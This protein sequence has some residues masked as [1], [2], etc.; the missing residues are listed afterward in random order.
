[1]ESERLVESGVDITKWVINV[2]KTFDTAHTVFSTRLNGYPFSYSRD[3]TKESNDVYILNSTGR[4]FKELGI[5][6]NGPISI[7]TMD[8]PYSLTAQKVGFFSPDMVTKIYKHHVAGGYKID[9]EMASAVSG[10]TVLNAMNHCYYL[11][12]FFSLD[13][14]FEYYVDYLGSPDVGVCVMADTTATGIQYW[15]EV[16]KF[17]VDSHVSI[18]HGS[19]NLGE[20][21]NRTAFSVEN[22]QA[23]SYIIAMAMAKTMN[24]GDG[25]KAQV[26]LVGSRRVASL[27]QSLGSR[28]MTWTGVKQI[29]DPSKLK[30]LADDFV[31]FPILKQMIYKFL[32]FSDAP[33]Y[34]HVKMILK[35]TNML[36]FM[37]IHG[38]LFTDEPTMA[39]GDQRIFKEM[40][41]WIRNFTTIKKAFGENWPYYKI[42]NPVGDLTNHS[43]FKRL[44]LYAW[45]YTIKNATVSERRTMKNIK[46]LSKPPRIALQKVST[47]AVCGQSGQQKMD[48]VLKEWSVQFKLLGTS[49]D[50]AEAINA[51]TY[52]EARDGY[53][54]ATFEELVAHFTGA[55][56]REQI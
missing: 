41:I 50:L 39:H 48:D 10:S 49:Y 30:K 15:Q 21:G 45:A 22:M 17:M 16:A 54:G 26:E 38:F 51:Q 19:T 53:D 5:A 8:A 12:P 1:M 27:A 34:S 20:Y 14:F 44:A 13:G 36:P 23:A 25:D 28:M 47:L 33:F 24:E 37:M 55:N 56:A 32:V 43:H 40:T 4:F 29:V 3:T 9:Y 52:A 2:V 7:T 42:L 11:L 31:C 6:V 18:M 35:Y 46:G